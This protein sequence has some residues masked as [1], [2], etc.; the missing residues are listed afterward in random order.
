VI[1]KSFKLWIILFVIINLLLLIWSLGYFKFLEEKTVI[2]DNVIVIKP[3]NQFKKF[4]P[5]EDESFPN[6]K[7]K[8]W[9]AFEDKKNSEQIMQENTDEEDKTNKKE[10]DKKMESELEDKGNRSIDDERFDIKSSKNNQIPEK[11]SSLEKKK[12]KDNLINNNNQ[13]RNKSKNGEG[14]KDKNADKNLVFYVQVASLSK[15]DLVKKEWNRLKKKHTKYM[16]NYIYISQKA[17]LKDNRVFFRLL[18][19]KFMSKREANDFC[20]KLSIRKCI[21]KKNNE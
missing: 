21:V 3:D 5:P 7:S 19:G 1:N 11:E 6:E 20:N 15:K 4:L 16:T 13:I 8:V 2:S 18:V 10:N 12:L 9:G 17:E 14:L